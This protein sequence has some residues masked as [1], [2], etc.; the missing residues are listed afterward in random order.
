MID[1]KVKFWK[2]IFMHFQRPSM[3]AWSNGRVPGFVNNNKAE[4][5]K[6]LKDW[7]KI[8]P[9]KRL[10]DQVERIF[11]PLK[12]RD[13]G[14][15]PWNHLPKSLKWCALRSACYPWFETILIELFLYP[16]NWTWPID[17]LSLRAM[18][19]DCA[20]YSSP[21]LKLTKSAPFW[22]SSLCALGS[23]LN[24]FF[25]LWVGIFKDS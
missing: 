21:T 4:S 19:H 18:L 25:Q 7:L 2:F 1:E 11:N 13:H 3:R 16:T 10:A 17:Y 5:M 6:F 24:A 14:N 9:E 20:L 15:P 23:L 12:T 22:D 8:N